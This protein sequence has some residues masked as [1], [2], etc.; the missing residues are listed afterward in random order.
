MRK[1]IRNC[2]TIFGAAV[3]EDVLLFS[4]FDRLSSTPLQPD[5]DWHHVAIEEFERLLQ[6]CPNWSWRAFLGLCR[7][8]GLRQAEALN[9]TWDRIDW[10]RH[11]IVVFGIKTDRK[12][13]VPIEPKLEKILLEAYGATPDGVEEVAHEVRWNNLRRTFHVIAKRAGLELWEKWCHTLRKNAETD[14]AQRY[15]QYVVSYWLG[16]GIEVSEKYYLQVPEELYERVAGIKP[17]EPSRSL[18]LKGGDNATAAAESRAVIL[19]RTATKS[20]TN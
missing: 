18:T 4:P 20:A 9:L 10:T 17:M 3:K 15:P 19:P 5:K 13:V 12:R 1:H 16:H 2:K 6:A 8:A 11:R 14:W 7:L